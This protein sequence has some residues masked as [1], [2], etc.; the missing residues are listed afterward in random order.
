MIAFIKWFHR[1]LLRLFVNFDPPST[2]THFKG[3]VI[4]G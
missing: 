4:H 2:L 1:L 3:E